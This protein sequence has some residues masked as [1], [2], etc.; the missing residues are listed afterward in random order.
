MLEAIETATL[1]QVIIFFGSILFLIFLLDVRETMKIGEAMSKAP[2]P[3]HLK[4]AQASQNA[5][6]CDFKKNEG[7]SE[8]IFNTA[9]PRVNFNIPVLKYSDFPESNIPEHKPD[10]YRVWIPTKKINGIP[11]R[12]AYYEP[13]AKPEKTIEQVRRFNLADY[14]D[15]R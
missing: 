13:D 8:G 2:V 12:F 7:G 15:F 5:P 1:T 9:N 10:H 14:S 4:R 3:E 11:V 6:G